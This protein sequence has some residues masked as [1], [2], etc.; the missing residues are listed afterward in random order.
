[1][2]IANVP[3][4][5]HAQT[6]WIAQQRALS[7]SDIKGNK[8]NVKML[9]RLE[10]IDLARC[11][12]PQVAQDMYE[13]MKW[14]GIRWDEGPVRY[15][16]VAD[17]TVGAVDIC[18]HISVSTT[19]NSTTSG[20]NN[21]GDGC[22][23]K[24]EQ[25]Q[26]Q[27]YV[28][29]K[30]FSVYKKALQRLAQLGVVYP[31]TQS[32]KDVKEALSAPHTDTNHIYQH[33]K[34]AAAMAAAVADRDSSSAMPSSSTSGMMQLHQQQHQL[35]AVERA[36]IGADVI[37]PP[38]LRPL[39]MQFIAGD[40][41][42]SSNRN[43]SATAA[44]C[45]SSAIDPPRYYRARA[46]QEY[47]K[48]KAMAAAAGRN[49]NDGRAVIPPKKKKRQSNSGGSIS[50]SSNSSAAKIID[51]SSENNATISSSLSTVSG[52]CAGFAN[53]EENDECIIDT[54][55]NWRFRVPDGELISFEDGCF[56][57]PPLASSSD[58]TCSS[59]SPF[60]SSVENCSFNTLNSDSNS[61]SNSQSI[62][63]LF[64]GVDFGDFLVWRAADGGSPSYELAV[65]FAVAKCTVPLKHICRMLDIYTYFIF[66]MIYT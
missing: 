42:S 63:N 37:F 9:L 11:S 13:D 50:S 5:G 30:R 43:T 6:F 19:A 12:K 46:I 10:D 53:E 18:P 38:H 14:F 39:Y 28:Q 24:R 51:D 52:P 34:T 55:V 41:D 65:S 61:N 15:E 33:I 40:N 66:C 57:L 48:L 49:E 23:T 56:K 64:A 29:S 17:V 25:Q 58:A 27:Q 35:S 47:E 21:N 16:D 22:D 31:C 2:I 7:A 8:K 60:T 36:M 1:M 20:F 45:T 3:L 26:Q 32:R 59:P 62:V 44:A 4:V 54:N